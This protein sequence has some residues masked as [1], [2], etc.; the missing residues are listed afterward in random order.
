MKSD[1]TQHVMYGFL[2][3]CHHGCM[4]R[5]KKGPKE[6]HAT[7]PMPDDMAEALNRKEVFVEFTVRI[8]KHDKTSSD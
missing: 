7:I 4:L 2:H 6:H 1:T 5:L 3:V 8:P